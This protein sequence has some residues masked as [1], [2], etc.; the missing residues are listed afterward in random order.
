MI[1][2]PPPISTVA[3]QPKRQHLGPLLLL[4]LCY[5]AIGIKFFRFISRY[6]VNLFF[7]DQW[8]YADTTLFERHSWGEMFLSQH[9]PSRQGIGP[10]LSKLIDPWFHWSS[11]AQ[12]FEVGIVMVLASICAVYLKRR[13]FGKFDYFDV[14]IPLLF[15]VRSQYDS[16]IGSPSFTYQ[17]LP[18]LLVTLYCLAWTIGDHRWRYIVLLILNFLSIYTGYAIFIGILTLILLGTECLRLRN[19]TTREKKYCLFSLGLAVLS[20]ASFFIGYSFNPA[21]ECFST[22]IYNPFQYFKFCALMFSYFVVLKSTGLITVLVGSALLTAVLWSFGRALKHLL[23]RKTEFTQQGLVIATLS[24]YGILYCL[25]AAVGRI[26]LGMVGA[27]QSRYMTYMP[28]SFLAVY[29]TILLL[30]TGRAKYALLCIFLVT[31]AWSSLHFDTWDWLTAKNHSHD[32]AAWRECYL[33]LESID[34]CT[35]LTGFKVYPWPEGTHLKE[36]LDFLKQR[37]LN[38]YAEEQ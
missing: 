24:G 34:Q 38:L 37:H 6:S 30:R 14:S 33:K 25:N 18:P 21:L 23:V 7:W 8:D 28:L 5:I 1:L 10:I 32:R 35:A 22:R 36:K 13:L 31:S 3:Q 29:L 2:A 9:G 15:L 19:D 17:V 20:F 27:Q 16:L 11:R 12:A 4:G 26:C